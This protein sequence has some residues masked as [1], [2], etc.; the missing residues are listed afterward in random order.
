MSE[1]DFL[2]FGNG[3][4]SAHFGNGFSQKWAKIS[5]LIPNLDKLFP[6][7]RCLQDWRIALLSFGNGNGRRVFLG[8]VGNGNSR[9]PLSVP[10]HSTLYTWLGVRFFDNGRM[11]NG[12]FYL[13]IQFSSVHKYIFPTALF[14]LWIYPFHSHHPTNKTYQTI[15]ISPSTHATW[16][17]A[18]FVSK[19]NK[20][21][22][23]A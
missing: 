23:F 7:K 19:I 4:S 8:M 3:N 10:Q 6:G 13:G 18:R 21:M 2:D 14:D 5:D 15:Y 17:F 22:P 20:W 11:K 16:L 9:S 12:I 1:K